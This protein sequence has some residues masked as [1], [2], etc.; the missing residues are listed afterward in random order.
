MPYMGVNVYKAILF[1]LSVLF[2]ANA[3][4]VCTA[5]CKPGVSY[6]CGQGC[7]SIYKQCRK[8]TTTACNGERPATASKSYSKPQKVEPVPVQSQQAGK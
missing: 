8:P 7:I 3:S 1:G 5:Y 6:A 4:A 2:S